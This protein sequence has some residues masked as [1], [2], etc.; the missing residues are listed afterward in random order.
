MPTTRLELQQEV[1]ELKRKVAE[2]DEKFDRLL[3]DLHD[4]AE[5]HDLCSAFDDFLKDHGLP[6]RERDYEVTLEIT[7]KHKI[8]VKTT[9]EEEAENAQNDLSD[10]EIKKSLYEA[11]EQDRDVEVYDWNVESVEVV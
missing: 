3:N 8:S 6:G 10:A 7:L 11:I 9:N 5:E 4:A 2:R 1:E